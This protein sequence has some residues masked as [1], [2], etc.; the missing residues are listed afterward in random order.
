[1]RR[2]VFRAMALG[3]VRDRGALAMSFALPVAFFLVFAVI[4]AGASGESLRL[5]V[6]IGD[7]LAS[8]ESGRLLRAIARDPAV[9]VIGEPGADT[10]RVGALVRR[11]AAD[12]G[13][14]VRRQAEPLGAATGAGPAPV[15]IL[16]DPTRAVA[17][18]MLAGIVQRTY[19]A[20][21]PDVALGGVARVL[22]DGFVTLTSE[23]EDELQRGLAEL[24]AEASRADAEGRTAASGAEEIV[25]CLTLT[26]RSAREN[27]VAYYAGA[28]AFLFLLFSSVHG[29]L[30]LI[31]ERESGLL[32][33]LLAGPGGMAAL[34]DGKFLFVASQGFIQ[35]AVIFATAWLLYGVDLPGHLTGFAI[36]T[37]AAAVAAAGLALALAAACRTRRQA[38]TLANVVILIVSAIGGSMVPRFFMPAWLQDLGWLTPNTW[39]L[40]AYSAVFW[41]DE[42]LGALA[43]PLSLLA[44]MGGLGL[45]AARRLAARAARV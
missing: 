18:R 23:Q 27:H 21:L 44:G 5:R 39:A 31:E 29:A 24:R 33:R 2:A 26:G 20:A 30:S 10:A 13:L 12:A 4:F 38:Q 40:E 7:E 45:V 34:V 8:P 35:V 17:G 42:P 19:L 28:V 11:G 16:T 1:M 3:F 15:L 9:V 14:I 41:R 22:G 25:E 6:A 37:L 43:L 36:T 32:E